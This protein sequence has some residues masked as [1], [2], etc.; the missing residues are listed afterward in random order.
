MGLPH[1]TLRWHDGGPMG[2]CR[3]STQEVSL[4]R[5]LTQA[6]RRATLAHE[7]EHLAK[8]PAIVGFTDQDELDVRQR[9]ARWL[10]PFHRLADALVWAG[11]D[12]ELADE[13]W[14]DVHTVR[15]R[16]ETLTAKECA[17][18]ADLMAAAELTFPRA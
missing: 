8:G 7:L 9:A 16:L 2:K 6:E 13:L 1:I 18:L 15:T 14:V 4:R 11:D 3:H 10:I 17:H 12:Y 5:G